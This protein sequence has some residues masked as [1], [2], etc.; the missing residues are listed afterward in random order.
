[1]A[2][3]G[4]K[5][6]LERGGPQPRRWDDDPFTRRARRENY[7]ARSI[8]KLQEIQKRT[9]VLRK[10]GRVLDLGC[11]PGSWLL[12]AAEA[13]GPEGRV[14]GVDLTPVSLA[15]P[16][17]VTTITADVLALAETPAGI[18]GAPFDAVLSDMAPATTGSRGVDAARSFR[19]CAAALAI[20]RQLLKPGGAFVCKIFQ[21]EDFKGFVDAVKAGF[22]EHRIF[23]PQSSRKASSE[24][25]LIGK[26]KK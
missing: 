22:A 11:A 14:V 4:R 5:R 2:A 1:M 7:P 20:A 15:L 9:G 19:L 10:G 3:T 23:K 21:G 6:S 12:F 25:Y 24:I 8:Y 18:P 26:G 13:V 16:A 17:Q